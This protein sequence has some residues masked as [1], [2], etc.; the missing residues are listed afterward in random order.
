MDPTHASSPKPQLVFSSDL[1]STYY[2]PCSVLS[3][4]GSGRGGLKDWGSRE[5]MEEASDKLPPLG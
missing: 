3:T 4:T 2:K 5:G 1:L